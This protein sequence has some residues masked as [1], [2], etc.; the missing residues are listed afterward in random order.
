MEA[1][2]AMLSADKIY[3]KDNYIFIC[4]RS[5]GIHVL[6]NKDPK[7]PVQV[8]F[9]RIPGSQD[10]AIKGNIL[11]ADN[12]K[13][14]VSIDIS[15]IKEPKVLSRTENVFNVPQYPPHGNVK[16]EC[17]NPQKGILVGWE[18]IPLNSK[19]DCFR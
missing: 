14:L 9:L 2:K 15:N 1:P 10:V 5:K 11:Y 3:Y 12:Y 6:D 16:F 13:D 7:N 8:C 17:P 4:E 19:V 18:E